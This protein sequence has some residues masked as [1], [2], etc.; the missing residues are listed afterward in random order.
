MTSHE[1]YLLSN[2]RLFGCLFNSLC[3]RISKNH[4]CVHYWPF[5]RGI[6]RW[7]VNSP[8]KGP[9]TPKKLPCDDVIICIGLLAVS[10]PFGPFIPPIP[11]C[12]YPLLF[13]WYALYYLRYTP[14]P[15]G[16]FIQLSPGARFNIKMPSFQYRK[17]HCGDKTVVR[18]S[19]LHN[20]I[21]YTGKTTSLYWIRAQAVSLPFDL[22][23]SLSP[24]PRINIETVF[25][26]MGFPMLKIRRSRN[27]L[28][29]NMGIPMLVRRHLYI[30]TAPWPQFY[31]TRSAWS[32]DQGSTKKRSAVHNFV[33]T[34][35][36]FCVMWEGLSLPH[37]TKFGN[38]RGAIVDR[39]VIFIWSLIHGSSWSGLI[40]LGPGAHLSVSLF[41]WLETILTLLTL[42]SRWTCC[43][44]R[45][46]RSG[47]PCC[48][49]GSRGS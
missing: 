17:S 45:P 4:P 16:L 20:G 12:I 32:M 23:I 14:Y 30:G 43:W 5:V 39:R 19:Y 10:P 29:F 21:S 49:W 26:G 9:A 36:K 11:G 34:V 6:H 40:K 24:G 27:R 46:L 44:P 25:P 33:S 3:G 37:D 31:Q 22:F 48:T 18:S 47:H 8:H 7:P 28:I 42:L 13:L 38:C 35:T 2:H 41:H 15:V 1:R